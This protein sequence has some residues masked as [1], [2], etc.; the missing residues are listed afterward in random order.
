VV[1]GSVDR[2]E[3]HPNGCVSTCSRVHMYEHMQVRDT[4]TA[5]ALESLNILCSRLEADG[6]S[7]KI[8]EEIDRS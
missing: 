3:A 4:V 7:R 5:I 2:V 6:G 1:L 8:I